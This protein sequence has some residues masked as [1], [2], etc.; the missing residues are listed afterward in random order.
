M[1]KTLNR[2]AMVGLLLIGSSGGAWAQEGAMDMT[3]NPTDAGFGLGDGASGTVYCTTFQPDGKIIIGGTF[4][5]YNRR[6][7]WN[8]TRLNVDGT[9]DMSFNSGGPSPNAVRT[10][11]LQPDGKIIVGGEFTTYHGVSRNR[12]ARINSNNTLDTSFDPGSGANSAVLSVTLLPDGKTILAGHFTTYNGTGRNRIVRLNANGSLDTSFDPGTGAD[13]SIFQIVVQPDGKIIIVGGFDNY[14]GTARNGIARLNTDGTLDG[15]FDPG[16]GADGFIA[17][18]AMQADSKVLIGGTFTS[19]NGIARNRIARLNAGGS[20]DVTFNPGAGANAQISCLSLQPDN[21]VIMAGDFTLYN[22]SPRSRI[23][24]LHTDGSSDAS[25]DPGSGANDWIHTARLDANGRIIIGGVFSF[26]AYNGTACKSIVRLNVDGSIDPNFNPGM[27]VNGGGVQCIS[28]QADGKIIIGGSFTG[29]N[30]RSRVQIA[31]VD[32]D[33]SLDDSF[34]PGTGAVTGWVYATELQSNGKILVGGNFD[35]YNGIERRRIV[36]LNADGSLD[37]SFDPGSGADAS[38]RF[39]YVRP[40]GKILISGAFASYNGS[41]RNRICQLN[42][43]GSLDVAF[44]PGTGA[45]GLIDCFA[46]QPDGKIVIGGWF[47]SFNGTSINGIA[48]L[49]ADGSLDA[50]FNPGTGANQPIWS[51]ALQPNGKILIGGEFTTFNGTARNRIAR[52]N[53]DGSL[54]TTFNPGSGSNYIVTSITVRPDSKI[55]MGGYFTIYNGSAR[56]GI[57]LLN[58]DGSVAPALDPGQGTAGEWVNSIILQ[59]DGKI[60]IGGDFTSYNGGGRNRLARL[61]GT[62]REWIRV[63]LEGPYNAGAMTDALRTLPSFPL[64]EPFSAM[65]YANAAYA[66]A[67][68]ISSSVLTGTNAIV[69]WVIVEMRP[70]STPGTV[71]ACRAVLLQRDGDVVDLDGVSTVS[72]AG[73]AAGNYCVAVRSRNHLPVMSSLAAPI[74]YGAS[75]ATVDFTLPSTLVYDNDARKYVSGAM[76]L[77]AGDVTF[78]QTVSYIGAGNDRD[79]ILTRVGGTAPNSSVA[80]YYREDVNM[81]GVVKY[82]GLNNDRDPILLNVGST[83]PNSTRVAA[84]P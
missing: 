60:I 44:D 21:K 63:M 50:T 65:G 28:M 42:N 14:N 33:G 2:L 76:V 13:N 45:N 9:V 62:S 11:A 61:K 46:V 49:N 19:Y 70:V 66:P 32:A 6:N 43:D 3:F 48:R 5:S 78:N 47:T 54:D 72:F 27:G 35:Q 10:T 17:S 38:V 4:G 67:A 81:D 57:A 40:D 84:L 31:R 77:A 39:I 34:N 75:T 22:G 7:V 37:P 51:L 29:Y 30:G 83:T 36:R 55:L 23:V 82:T 12:I 15:S 79:A 59:P 64:T 69:D 16:T 24:R 58:T 56:S 20:L 73:L 26:K 8:I 52:L 74:S 41:V 80:G 53:A 68:T 25:F 71:A 18:I 1:T